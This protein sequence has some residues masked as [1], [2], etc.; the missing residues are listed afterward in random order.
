MRLSVG[1]LIRWAAILQVCLAVP[2]TL[3]S[4]SVPENSQLRIS[5]HLV[6]FG[7]IV[8]DARGTLGNLTKDDFV[9]LDRGKPQKISVFSAEPGESEAQAAKPLPQNT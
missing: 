1:F 4:Q 6:Q 9:V 8:R 5:T 2:M 3:G 7:V